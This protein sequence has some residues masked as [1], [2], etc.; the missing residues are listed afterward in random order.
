MV[1]KD[2]C[3]IGTYNCYENEKAQ[4]KTLVCNLQDSSP[5]LCWDANKSF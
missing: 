5:L 2:G 3:R 4:E 1:F